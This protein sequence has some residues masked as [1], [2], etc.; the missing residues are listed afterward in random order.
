VM[1]FFAITYVTASAAVTLFA[2]SAISSAVTGVPYFVDAEIPTA[3][4]LGMHLLVTDPSTSPR[5]PLGRVLFG[6]AY[7][8]CVFGLYALLSA[9]GV[10]TFYDKL[11]AVPLLNLL[12][13][14]I[15]RVVAGIGERR[16]VTWLGL[17]PP[18]GQHNLKHMAAWV[19]FFAVMTVAGRTDGMHR[20]DALPF[21]IDACE[22]GKPQACEKL[23]RIEGSYCTDN[24]G[25]ACNEL[26]RHY[27]EGRL[28]PHDP[29]RA[30]AYFARACEGRFQAGCVNLLDEAPRSLPPPRAFDLRLLVREGGLN[31]TDMPEPD[32]YA[33]A[34]RHGWTFACDKASASR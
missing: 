32:L 5:L 28:V 22:A 17:E 34:C 11:L 7:G 2:L 23:L 14:A 9:L 26:G 16:W 24:A 20:G 27:A 8:C 1:Y 19:V 29:D 13:P 31:L 6:V 4:F 30:L 15:D 33:R 18:L 12:V 3:V 25:W 10:P 21:W